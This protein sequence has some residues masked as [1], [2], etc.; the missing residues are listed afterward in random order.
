MHTCKERSHFCIFSRTLC[1]DHTKRSTHM[2]FIVLSVVCFLLPTKQDCMCFCR[3]GFP[4]RS[5]H[6]LHWSFCAINSH[7]SFFPLK[8]VPFFPFSTCIIINI[9]GHEPN[10]SSRIGYTTTDLRQPAKGCSGSVGSW[11]SAP[12]D[13]ALISSAAPQTSV[14]IILN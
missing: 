3:G 1:V 6:T 8:K 13:K 2:I 5:S 7:L 10:S 4:F 12:L 9:K 11:S 14:N